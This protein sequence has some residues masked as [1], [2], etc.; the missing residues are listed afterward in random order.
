[1]IKTYYLLTKPGIIMGNLITTASGFFLASRGHIDIVLF[2]FTMIGLGSIIASSCVCNNYIDR[3]SDR[4]M[5]RTKNRALASGTISHKKALF[6]AFILG[7]IGTFTLFIA[8]NA[9]S[10]GL[11]LFGFVIYAGCYSLWKH[12]S[13][14]ATLV[15]SIAG[16][17]PPVVGYTAVSGILDLGAILFFL[18]LV[19]WQMPHFFAITIYRQREYDHASIPTMATRRGIWITKLHMFFYIIAFLFTSSLLLLFGYTGLAY[20][21]VVSLLSLSWLVLCIK[22]FRTEDHVIWARQMFRLSLV[23][24]VGLSVMVSLDVC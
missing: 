6:F 9:L 19:L 14:A 17:I 24:I 16:A 7:V 21:A 22:G 13:S 10:L 23:V 12:H 8:T 3:E 5:A 11:A 1:M 18:L 20:L 4:K 2:F 15:G